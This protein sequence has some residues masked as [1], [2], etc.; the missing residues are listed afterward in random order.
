MQDLNDLYYFVKAVEFGGFAP[1]GRELG[2]PKSKLSRRIAMLEEKLG[3]RLIQ[4]STRHFQVTEIG[5]RYFEHCSAMLIE[6]EAAQEAIDIVRVEPRGRI[7]VTCPVGLL[8]FHVGQ[9]LA[10]FMR[11]Y[12]QVSIDLE[13]TNRRVDVLAEGV[14]IALRVR[15]LPLDDSNLVLRVLSDR[16]QCLVASA[17]LIRQMGGQPAEPEALQQWPSLSRAS[18]QEHHLWRLQHKD[19]R[20]Q[21]VP[22]EP[23]YCT[24]DMLTL[25]TA[26]IAGVGV[27]QLPL[28]M[29]PDELNSGALVRVLPEWEPRREVIHLVFPSRR[30]MLPAV[31]ALIDYLAEQYDR[32]EED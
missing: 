4:R 2:I 23:R 17:D 27:V 7:R 21:D 6:A 1:A 16:G 20:K 11:Q 15:P 29:L 26:A 10:D 5:E 9:M 25:K 24:T 19:G 31:R 28:L 8:H 3:V 32:I 14:D 12:P 22:F 30:G 13:A 18:R